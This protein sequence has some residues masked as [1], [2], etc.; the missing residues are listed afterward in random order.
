MKKLILN[1]DDLDYTFPITKYDIGG[2]GHAIVVKAKN[3]KKAIDEMVMK[4]RKELEEGFEE[5]D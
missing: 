1:L 5:Y 2:M 3:K 4:F